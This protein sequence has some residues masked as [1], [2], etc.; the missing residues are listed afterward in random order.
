MKTWQFKS[1]VGSREVVV[2]VVASYK[3]EA[4]HK[5]HELLDDRCRKAGQ[6]IPEIRTM[7]LVELIDVRHA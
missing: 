3:S 5:A 2:T 7:K 6:P 4:L 1:K